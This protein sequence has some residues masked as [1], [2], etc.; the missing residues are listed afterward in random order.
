VEHK[1]NIIK[2]E[3]K[4]EDIYLPSTKEV[5][6]G[7][8][9]I[10]DKTVAERARRLATLKGTTITQAVAEALEASLKTAEHHAKLDR[11]ARERDVDE[12]LKRIRAGIPP[13]APSYREIMEDMYEE[14][15]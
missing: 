12:I 6:M 3:R 11:E 1:E 13:D 8:L 15:G 14:N 4:K 10:K 5:A 7:A 9:N 2:L